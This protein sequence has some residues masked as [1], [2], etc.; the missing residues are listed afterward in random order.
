M[1]IT[2]KH[3]YMPKWYFHR[4]LISRFFAIENQIHTVMLKN[5][6]ESFENILQKVFE[7]GVNFLKT[8]DQRPTSAPQAVSLVTDLE[9]EG[10]GTTAVLSEFNQRFD[11]LIVASSGPRSWGFVTGG[12]TPAAVAGDWLAGVYDQN[13]QSVQGQGDLSALIEV[14]LEEAYVSQHVALV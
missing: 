14:E 4:Q 9:E 6:L 3:Q 10:K 13:P 8:I 2:G 11:P 1:S 12:A 7:Q 5:E